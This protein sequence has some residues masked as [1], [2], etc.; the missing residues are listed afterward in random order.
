[1][2]RFGVAS[3]G[4]LPALTSEQIG[5]ISRWLRG[6]WYRPAVNKKAGPLSVRH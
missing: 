6:S 2:P 3:E 4:G 5:L 1:M